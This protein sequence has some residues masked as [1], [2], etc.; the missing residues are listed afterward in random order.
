MLNQKIQEVFDLERLY[1]EVKSSYDILYK[2]LNIQKTV[3]FTIV[4]AIVLVASLI[5]NI[6]NFIELVK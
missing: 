6:L 5:I 2:E 1:G 3:K 4:I